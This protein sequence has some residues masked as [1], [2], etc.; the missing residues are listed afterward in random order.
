MTNALVWS[1]RQGNMTHVEQTLGQII[2][3]TNYLANATAYQD[4]SNQKL[5]TALKVTTQVTEQLHNGT[6]SATQA[7]TQLEEVV[8]EL[9]K[10]VG[11]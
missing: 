3:T 9:R 11:Q 6:T 5:A 2:A 8:S 1:W 7:A 4:A 10:V